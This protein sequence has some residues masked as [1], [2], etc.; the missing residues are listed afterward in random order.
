MQHDD[1]DALG[2]KPRLITRRRAAGLVLAG[3]AGCLID[4]FAIEPDLLSVT[5]QDVACKKLPPALDGLKVCLL[6]DFHF[7]PGTNDG[8]LDK[9]IARVRIEKPDLIALGGDYISS[10]VSV[11]QPLVEKLGQLRCAHGIFAIMGNHDGWC[12]DPAI[13]RR[14][15]ESKG[16]SFLI[17][18]HSQLHI[19]GEK[20]ALAGTDF[21]W[22]GRPDPVKTLKGVS[23]DTPVIALVHEPDYF[24]TMTAGRN[25]Q[26]QLSG[27][28]HGGQCRVPVIGYAPRK[29]TF[30]KKYIYGT[31]TRGDSTLFVTRGVGTSGPRVRFACPPELAMLTLRAPVL[32]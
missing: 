28:T 23:A 4:G 2:T 12:G 27:H 18:Q 20:L 25:I 19:R 24:D 17:N 6:A 22:K 14:Q 7:L 21:V 11:V 5:R 30:G 16:I 15:F 29:V 8:L 10:D 31:Y 32:S 1:T 13:I 9:I 3:A 26:L